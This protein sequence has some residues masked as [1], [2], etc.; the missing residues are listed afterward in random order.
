MKNSIKIH[1]L[2]LCVISLFGCSEKKNPEDAHI[3]QTTKEHDHSDEKIVK[4]TDEQLKNTTIQTTQCSYSPFE[5]TLQLQG[6][7]DVPPQSLISVSFPLNGTIVSTT[8][9]PGTYVK[10]GSI[11][12]VIEDQ[13]FLELQQEYLLTKLEREQLGKE[14]SRQKNLSQVDAT[15]KK[16]YE[17][18]STKDAQ[19][20]VKQNTL[21]KKL[22]LIGVNTEQLQSNS[23]SSK[24]VIRSPITGYITK[25]HCNIGMYVLQGNPLFEIVDPTHIHGSLTVFEKD[26]DKIKIGQKVKIVA[27]SLVHDTIDA[28][29]VLMSKS[30]NEDRSTTIHCHFEKIDDHLLPGMFLRGLVLNTGTTTPSIEESAVI[31]FENKTYIFEKK[32]K[33]EY[34]LQEIS[35]VGEQNSIVYFTSNE[36]VENKQ[37]VT[38]G[39]FTLLSVLKNTESGHSH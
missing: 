31:R 13:L 11:V 21:K 32:S 18:I 1:I 24:I 22:Q 3:H 36:P 16:L 2:F 26:I 27:P 33:N 17:E 9:L 28:E 6:V 5:E 14:L 34:H 29:I 25:V 19:M 4:L 23:M 8:M 38:K 30:I 12:A 39:S 37:Y 7:V 15:S 35:I 20:E 10:K